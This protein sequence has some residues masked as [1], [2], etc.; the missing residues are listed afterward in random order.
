MADIFY[1]RTVKYKKALDAGILLDNR[2][3]NTYKESGVSEIHFDASAFNA[4]FSYDKLI[5]LPEYEAKSKLWMTY[6]NKQ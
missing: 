6:L 2:L 4:Y 5:L 3:L 1:T